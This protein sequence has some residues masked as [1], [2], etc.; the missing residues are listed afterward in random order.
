MA[1]SIARLVF[2]FLFGVV[3]TIAAQSV[4]QSYCP[5]RPCEC[6]SGCGCVEP[7]KRCQCEDCTCDPVCKCRPGLCTCKACTPPV[8]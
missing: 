2:A 7:K 6:G 1:R 8:K 4:H 5:C 3:S